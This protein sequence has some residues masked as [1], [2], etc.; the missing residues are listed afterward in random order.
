MG[1]MRNGR[2]R[3]M[4]CHVHSIWS[5]VICLS[6]KIE[7]FGADEEL[8]G[9]LESYMIRRRQIVHVGT[10]TSIEVMVPFGV[11]QGGG[12]SPL[13]FIVFTS[14]MEEACKEAMNLTYAD[15]TSALV[16]GKDTG[17]LC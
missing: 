17:S 7:I 16:I 1:E 11:P 15:D 9:S 3:T 12:L 5:T 13:L 10:E 6:K 4:T 2:E 8:C 14:N